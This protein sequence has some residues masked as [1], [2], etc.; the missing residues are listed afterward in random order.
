[1][2]RLKDT[3]ANLHERLAAT[4]DVDPELRQLLTV[5]DRDIHKLLEGDQ[6]GAEDDLAGR[7]ESAASRFAANHPQLEPILREIAAVLARAGI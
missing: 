3:L 6:A 2:D 5:L 4:E 1:M 7:A